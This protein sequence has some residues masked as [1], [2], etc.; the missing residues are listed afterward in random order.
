MTDQSALME[1]LS[2]HFARLEARIDNMVTRREHEVQQKD[3]DRAHEKHRQLED[4]VRTLETNAA[5]GDSANSV[6]WGVVAK[7]AGVVIT[8]LTMG[9]AM[10]LGL[11]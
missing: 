5:K 11:R 10:W 7:V 6:R 9:M 4:R 8:L 2:D 1:F 3:V